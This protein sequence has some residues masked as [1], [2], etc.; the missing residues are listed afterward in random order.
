MLGERHT[1]LINGKIVRKR[2]QYDGHAWS[3]TQLAALLRDTFPEKNFWVRVQ[4]TLHCLASVPEPDL[5][6]IIG[7]AKATKT[8]MTGHR[9]ALVVEVAD[10]TLLVDTRTKTAIYT[11]AGVPEYWVLDVAHRQI[12]VHRG[13]ALV[14]GRWRYAEIIRNGDR[15]SIAPLAATKRKARI[16]DFLP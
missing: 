13:P 5:A 3:V 14:R 6:V 15:E 7:P 11:A 16:S 10:S 12:I 8:Y 4:M 2:P 1:E 9:A